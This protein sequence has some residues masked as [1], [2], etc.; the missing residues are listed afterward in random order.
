MTKCKNFIKTKVSTFFAPIERHFRCQTK[1]T[2]APLFIQKFLLTLGPLVLKG[3]KKSFL[4]LSGF[5]ILILFV[6]EI[7]PLE[8]KTYNCLTFHNLYQE[9]CLCQTITS[10]QIKLEIPAW[11]GFEGLEKFFPTI[12]WFFY[13]EFFW[14]EIWLTL[15]EWSKSR[16]THNHH[17]PPNS[18]NFD[19]P[20]LMVLDQLLT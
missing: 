6:V 16:I 18:Q 15:A 2:G 20:F 3:M 12:M 4:Q 8:A 17:H 7:S 10:K 14:V 19:L 9:G 1:P 5:F 13:L 11:S